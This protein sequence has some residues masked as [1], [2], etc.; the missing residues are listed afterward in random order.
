MIK[1][2]NKSGVVGEFSD[3]AWKLL[4]ENK[5]GWIEWDGQ[6]KPI[7][8]PQQIIEF[9]AKKKEV[10]VVAENI[11]VFEP[12]E[13][14]DDTEAMKSFL[15]EKGI[16]FHHKIGYAKLKALYDDNSK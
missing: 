12:T 15:T 14:T 6:P 1:A 3:I 4:G 7:T 9:Q 8:V 16:K 5:G 2:I 13:K 11:T 10:A